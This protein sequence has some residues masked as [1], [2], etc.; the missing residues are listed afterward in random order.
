[1]TI[2]ELH[3]MNFNDAAS[4]LC[5]ETDI[6]TTYENL[7]DFAKYHIDNDNLFLAIHI[8][9]AINDSPADFYAY[10]YCMG[11]L[12]KPTALLLISDLEDYCE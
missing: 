2:K 7:K 12:D 9:E 4:A 10:D 6:V 5:Y 1:M 11:T 3:D 8:L